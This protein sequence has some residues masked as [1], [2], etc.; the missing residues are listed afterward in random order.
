MKSIYLTAMS[1]LLLSSNA[2]ADR[3]AQVLGLHLGMP[4]KEVIEILE[5]KDNSKVEFENRN[6]ERELEEFTKE[7]REKYS[8]VDFQKVDNLINKAKV[9]NF[10][11]AVKQL[12][13]S[14]VVCDSPFFKENNVFWFIA[15][16]N[17]QGRLANLSVKQRV[18]TLDSAVQK[19]LEELYQPLNVE[20]NISEHHSAGLHS[21]QMGSE[22]FDI[23]LKKRAN[24]KLIEYKLYN[25]G[26]F[27]ESSKYL[28]QLVNEFEEN[29]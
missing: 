22:S 23:S 8:K 7:Y 18:D 12:S 15:R 25:Y 29:L 1:L 27:G 16:F 19:E 2:I 11:S 26:L 17:D 24:E 3:G 9:A 14:D 6:L 13:C 4:V 10:S 20:G 5:L 28:N 21:F